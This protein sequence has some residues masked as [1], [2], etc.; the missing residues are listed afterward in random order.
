[1]LLNLARS[2]NGHPDYYLAIGLIQNNYTFSSQTAAGTTGSFSDANTTATTKNSSGSIV[3]RLLTSV[4]TTVFGYNFNETVTATSNPQFQFIPINNEVA[5][6]QVLEPISKP[7]SFLDLYQ[8]WAIRLTNWMRVMIGANALE[9]P[10]LQSGEH[11]VLGQPHH[12]VC[13]TPEYYER[14]LRA[15]AILRTFAGRCMD[16]SRLKPITVRKKLGGFSAS[17]SDRNKTGSVSN[18][19]TEPG[20]KR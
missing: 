8:Q 13:G 14:F 12:N 18:G 15:C 11:L 1:M 7:T 2:E 10:R 9:T 6:R 4:L 16:T 3:T 19:A 17:Q 20:A 5:A